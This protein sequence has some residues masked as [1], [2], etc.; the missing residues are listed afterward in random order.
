[1][2]YI[3]AST[4]EIFRRMAARGPRPKRRAGISAR[5]IIL[6][7]VFSL[8]EKCSAATASDTYGSGT[9]KATLDIVISFEIAVSDVAEFGITMRPDE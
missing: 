8:T 3:A 1:M 9:A 7:N 2:G 6:R 4:S 5:E